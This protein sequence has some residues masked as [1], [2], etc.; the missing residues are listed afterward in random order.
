VF[1]LGVDSYFTAFREADD[2]AGDSDGRRPDRQHPSF[3]KLQME[4]GST[5]SA[6][7]RP[8]YFNAKLGL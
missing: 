4:S 5:S 8:L 2:G 3:D 7:R 6:E 1:H